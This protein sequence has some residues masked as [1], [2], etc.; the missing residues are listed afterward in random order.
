MFPP[1]G[2]EVFKI[3]ASATKIDLENI[4]NYNGQ[5]SRGNL[6]PLE[7][8]VKKLYNAR[9]AVGSNAANGNA[10]VTNLLFRIKPAK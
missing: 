7:M 6:T 4:A 2:T 9:E 1:F 8:L 3:F 10:T 5:S